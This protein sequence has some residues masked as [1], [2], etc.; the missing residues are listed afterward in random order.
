MTAAWYLARAGLAVTLWEASPALGGRLAGGAPVLLRRGGEEFH[1]PDEHGVHAIW[2]Q[3]HNVR[4]L[5]DEL[6]L[7]HRLFDVGTQHHLVPDERGGLRA[8]DIGESV[9]R[10]RLPTPLA[11]LRPWLDPR[12][13]APALGAGPRALARVAASLG[14]ALAFDPAD[15]LDLARYDQHTIAAL[16]AGWPREFTHLFESLAHAAYFDELD[17]VSL[18]A[19]CAGLNLYFVNH[20]DDSRFSV[21]DDDADAVWLAPMR[22]AMV[23]AGVDLRLGSTIEALAFEGESAPRATRAIARGASGERAAV[24]ADGYVLALD[25]TGL[26]RLTDGTPLAQGDGATRGLPSVVLRLWFDAAPQAARATSGM[27]S[28]APCDAFFWLHRWMNAYRRWHEATGGGVLELHVYGDHAGAPDAVLA[29]RAAAL[30]LRAW[31][32]LRRAPAHVTTRRNPP[33]Q[34]ALAPGA[35]STLP[36]VSTPAANVVRCGDAVSVDGPSLFLER[37][38]ASAVEAARR[39][40]ASLGVDPSRVPAPLALAPPDPSV[41]ALRRLARAARPVLPTPWSP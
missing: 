13:L 5:L 2:R 6:H 34:V 29:E 33:T 36:R 41:A 1:F 9:R 39:L 32:E 18:A 19:F 15:P 38:C 24:T 10:S 8:V 25:P 16:V 35:F 21:F 27:F 7:S 28:D 17:R 30:A 20:Q 11:M 40:A 12:L 31:P 14:A 37:A 23:R 3:Y 22:G 4:R 26:R